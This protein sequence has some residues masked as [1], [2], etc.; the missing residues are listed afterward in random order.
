LDKYT[1][2]IRIVFALLYSITK[3]TMYMRFIQG[4]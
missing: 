4:Q 1:Q 2:Q 3:S